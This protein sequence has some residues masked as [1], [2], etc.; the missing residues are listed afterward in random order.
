M[1]TVMAT[2]MATHVTGRSQSER[3]TLDELDMTI[4]FVDENPCAYLD[5]IRDWIAT[6]MGA[7][8]EDC[9]FY[10]LL[11]KLRYTRKSI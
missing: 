9:T 10:K 6:Q 1:A 3:F 7:Y 5:E 8:V 11:K 4:K 2:D